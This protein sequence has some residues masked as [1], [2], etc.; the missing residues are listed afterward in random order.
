[1]KRYESPRMDRV[2]MREGIE[3]A[4]GQWP[5]PKMTT[6][7]GKQF[8]LSSEDSRAGIAG[9]TFMRAVYCDRAMWQ[10]RF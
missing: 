9:I 7:E 4:G 3:A 2:Q 6:L 5:S 1:M 10:I 8:R